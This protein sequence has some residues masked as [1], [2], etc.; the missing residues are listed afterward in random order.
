MTD[1][2]TLHERLHEIQKN[3]NA[4][5]SQFNSF[6]KYHY[7]SCED[8]IEAV[9]LLLE[10]C[11][12][13]LISDEIIYIGQRYYIKASACITNGQ[14]SITTHALAREPEDRK[15]MDASQITGATSSYAR[16]YALNGLFAI[17]DSKDADHDNQPKKDFTKLYN[18]L[19]ENCVNKATTLAA[20]KSNWENS[21]DDIKSL[22]YSDAV[23]YQDLVA[24]KDAK[25]IELTPIDTG[26]DGKN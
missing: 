2:K 10:G 8:I 21:I 7:R 26:F 9:K 23:K 18:A 24:K 4:P 16:K 22:Q 19:L 11:E 20:L 3:L 15:G 5:K 25:K 14:T 17:D 6:G 12:S 13:L 1:K